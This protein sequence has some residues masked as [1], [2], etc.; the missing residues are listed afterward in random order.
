MKFIMKPNK[1]KQFLEEVDNI[2]LNHGINTPNQKHV[3]DEEGLSAVE[4]SSIFIA[5][6]TP[7][8]LNKIQSLTKTL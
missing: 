5:R 8:Q 6:L 1:V 2:C 7:E 3:Y 4:F